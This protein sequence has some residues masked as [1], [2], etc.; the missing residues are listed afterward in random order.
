MSNPQGPYSPV[1]PQEPNSA[2]EA[3]QPRYGQRSDNWVPPVQQ[4]G[5]AY[6]QPQ[7]QPQFPASGPTGTPGP[8]PG[9]A[10]P[11]GQYPPP[12]YPPQGS[13]GTPVKI[14]SRAGAVW[15]LV[16]GLVMAIIIAPGVAVGIIVSAFDYGRMAS[17]A[18]ETYDG[19]TVTVDDTGVIALISATGTT[20]Q[21][22]SIT[23]GSSSWELYQ[24]SDSG[25][26]V[27]RGIT[28]GTYTLSC[29]GGTSSGT[30]FFFGGDE[31][32]GI[33]SSVMSAFVWGTVIGLVGL[34]LTIVGIVFLVRKNRQIKEINRQQWGGYSG[35][36]QR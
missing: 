13:V 7:P 22:C 19:G 35:Y 25:I 15:A 29:S 8:Y 32:S 36:V 34:A 24:E 1:P 20:P 30:L 11:Q 14:P 4:P 28:P 26:V 12:G 6:S 31:L 9:P 18:M 10:A 17:G 33:M 16:V 2:P 21:G 3:A 23:D 27:G 5:S